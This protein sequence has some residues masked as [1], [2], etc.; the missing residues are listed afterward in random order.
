MPRKKP[1]VLFIITDHQ[2]AGLQ[3]PS[4]RCIVS[5]Q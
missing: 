1:N 2:G 3:S 5:F 4:K